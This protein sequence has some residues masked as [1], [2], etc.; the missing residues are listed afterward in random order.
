MWEATLGTV[1]ILIFENNSYTCQLLHG[2]VHT[3]NISLPY[4]AFDD[5]TSL[6][7]WKLGGNCN[8]KHILCKNQYGLE[9]EGGS[10]QSDSMNQK[11]V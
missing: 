3:F 2:I 10:V 8:N 4:I 5:V 9:N 6:Q 7:N 1:G 11:V